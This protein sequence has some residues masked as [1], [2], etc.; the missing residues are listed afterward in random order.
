MVYWINV[1]RLLSSLKL[2]LIHAIPAATPPY[3]LP[4][5][6]RTVDGVSCGFDTLHDTGIHVQTCE[7]LYSLSKA[8]IQQNS[9]RW[10]DGWATVQRQRDNYNT[11]LGQSDKT[12]KHTYA[13]NTNQIDPHPDLRDARS[14]TDLD[15]HRLARA[16]LERKH[17]DRGKWSFP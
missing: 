15:K 11:I 12:Y 14:Q 9:K 10:L 7:T 16:H 4:R 5:Y 6:P 1:Y 3:S 17:R 13:D 2:S 8:T